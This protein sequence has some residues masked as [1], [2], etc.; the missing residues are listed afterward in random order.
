M[1]DLLT[2]ATKGMNLTDDTKRTLFCNMTYPIALD[3]VFVDEVN[4]SDESGS[5]GESS[6]YKTPFHAVRQLGGTDQATIMIKKEGS[7][8]YAEIAKSA[9]KKLQ[10]TLDGLRKKEAKAASIASSATTTKDAEEEDEAIVEDASLPKAERI[11][12]RQATESRGIRVVVK[13]WV[14]TAR[15]Q[16]RKLVFLDLRDGSDIYLQCV[17]TG[18]L[19]LSCSKYTND[20]PRVVQF[21]KS[22]LRPPS[23]STASSLL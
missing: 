4:G 12:I 21:K 7:T 5:G 3:K 22:Q 10:K 17:L 15:I 13:G 2:K 20:R 19:V 18:K 14:A 23:P 8:E 6:P 16:S 1:T 11:K 9:A